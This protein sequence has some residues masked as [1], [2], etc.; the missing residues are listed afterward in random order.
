MRAFT[1]KFTQEIS[2]NLGITHKLHSAWHFQSSVEKAHSALRRQLT[3]LSLELHQ[4]WIELLPLSVS[5][6]SNDPS[7]LAPLIFCMA[8]PSSLRSNYRATSLCRL[9]PPHPDEVT[10]WLLR[11]QVHQILPKLYHAFSPYPIAWRLGLP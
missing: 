11:K 5:H 9:S 10:H 7:S 4:S 3:T 8:A 6:C 2:Q 1:P